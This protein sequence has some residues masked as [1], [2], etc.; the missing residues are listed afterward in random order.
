MKYKVYI[1]ILLVCFGCESSE[2]K[3]PHDADSLNEL[4]KVAKS[5]NNYTL[6]ILRDANKF[7]LE[8]SS[9]NSDQL[10]SNISTIDKLYKLNNSTYIQSSELIGILKNHNQTSEEKYQIKIKSDSIDNSI[11]YY[12]YLDKLINK[13]SLS[14]GTV[15]EPRL[16]LPYAIN[17]SKFYSLK[18]D[19]ISV[20][21]KTFRER[22]ITQWRYE[23]FDTLNF[24]KTSNGEGNFTIYTSDKQI[25][26][27]IEKIKIYGKDLY[28]NRTEIIGNEDIEITLFER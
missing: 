9:S 22:D 7:I 2:I 23:L 21:I 12:V 26:K 4:L 24:H 14:P 28:T 25:G 5:S 20:P 1:W 16:L 8:V 17:N 18:G 15:N 6:N 11:D 27:S 13:G 3:N 19:T 10:N